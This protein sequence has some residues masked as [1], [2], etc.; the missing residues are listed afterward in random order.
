MTLVEDVPAEQEALLKPIARIAHL[1]ETNFGRVFDVK[2][3]P[4]A[5]SAAYTASTC[6]RTR[7]C[8]RGNCSRACS[9]CIASS[10]TRPAARACSSTASRSASACGARRPT[11][12]ARSRRR[13]WRSG[14]GTRTDYRWSAPILALDAE[15][16]IEE[17]RF[18]NFLRGPIDAPE[19]EMGGIYE[20]LRLFQAMTR[21]ERFSIERRLR[22][23]DMWAFD[24]RRVLHARREFDPR[25]GRAASARGL[26]RSRRDLFA[27]AR[28]EA[29]TGAR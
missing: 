9:S 4:A 12:S 1:R 16:E 7:T 14:T 24:N 10:T 11:R 22:P 15:G 23:G 26:C 28:A 21:D 19:S 13:R 6:R 29:R 2:S 25:L 8:R 27:L 3:K 17:V 5:D 18:A 20:A